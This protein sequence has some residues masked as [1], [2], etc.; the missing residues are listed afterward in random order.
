ML[1]LA[2]N[3]SAATQHFYNAALEHSVSAR[4]VEELYYLKETEL[5]TEQCSTS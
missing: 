1:L 5:D 4:G 3:S 2:L